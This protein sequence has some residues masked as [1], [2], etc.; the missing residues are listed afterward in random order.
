MKY[1]S[2]YIE[3]A[4]S[5]AINKADGFFAFGD[6]QF[7]EAKKD[8]LKYTHLGAGLICNKEKAKILIKELDE[9]VKAGIAQ[10]VK[11][12]GIINIIKRELSNHE[13]G[14]TGDITD[15]AEAL[16]DYPIKK[17]KILEIFKSENKA[18]AN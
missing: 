14:Y 10:D 7:N 11:E 4:Q 3:K 6:E 13:A 2:D 15:T 9:I 8:K 1:L 12:N 16:K 17:E 18:F 5:Q